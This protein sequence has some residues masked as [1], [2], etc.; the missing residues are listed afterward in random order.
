[1]LLLLLACTEAPTAEG[2]PHNPPPEDTGETGGGDT[3]TGDS[4]DTDTGGSGL[5]DVRNEMIR[6]AEACE[7]IAG[8][9]DVPAAQTYYWGEFV[10]S[11]A[12]GWV[13]EEAWYLFGNQPWYAHGLEDCEVWYDVVAEPAATGACSSC[14]AGLLAHATVNLAKTTCNASQYADSESMEEPYAI[15][16]LGDGSVDWYFPGSGSQYGRGYWNEVAMNYLADGG[17]SLPVD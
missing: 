5:K 17:C 11:D 9:D 7:V 4:G 2:Y 14:D 6:G 12:A 15:E 13:G 3:D 10:G 16:R 8:H 1:M